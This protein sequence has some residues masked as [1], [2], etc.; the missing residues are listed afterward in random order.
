MWLTE[1]KSWHVFFLGDDMPGAC[2]RGVIG[3]PANKN[4][5]EAF[6]RRTERKNRL[7]ADLDIVLF[8]RYLIWDGAML[9]QTEDMGAVW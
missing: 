1:A 2:C 9:R 5:V 7:T 4:K 6:V 3:R 8:T